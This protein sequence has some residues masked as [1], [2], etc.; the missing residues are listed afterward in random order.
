MC[1]CCELRCSALEFE[2]FSTKV[3]SNPQMT[4]KVTWKAVQD[5]CKILQKYLDVGDSRSSSLRG[6]AG[7]AIGELDQGALTDARRARVFSEE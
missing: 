1:P 5:L 6:V 3:K 2:K 7:G 4:Q